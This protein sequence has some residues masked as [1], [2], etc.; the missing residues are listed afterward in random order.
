MQKDLHDLE[1]SI[2]RGQI[3]SHMAAA[4]ILKKYKSR[5]KSQ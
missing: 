5:Y 4:T 1:D 2:N 3:T